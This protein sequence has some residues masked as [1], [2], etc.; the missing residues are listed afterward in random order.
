[1]AS[2]DVL[3]IDG[4]NQVKRVSSALIGGGASAGRKMGDEARIAPLFGPDAQLTVAVSANTT[5]EIE[6]YIQYS[7]SSFAN[8]TLDIS[9]SAPVAAA[10]DMSYGVTT[11]GQA[12]AP[13]NVD[14]SGS[15]IS[16]LGVDFNPFN[17]QTVVVKGLVQTNAAGFVVVNWGDQFASA[18]ETINIHRNS[19][20][21]LTRLN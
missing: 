9:L 1:M 16:G 4:S 3:M 17:R 21:K 13:S 14:G 8:S 6:V 2:D 10:T 5:Y 19:F 12:V 15:L 20:I 11:S 18:G 7:G